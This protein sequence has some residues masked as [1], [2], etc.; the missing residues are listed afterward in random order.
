MVRALVRMRKEAGSGKGIER[1][2]YC[3]IE[4][5]Y[6]IEN[7]N[8][9]V[10]KVSNAILQG[11]KIQEVLRWSQEVYKWSLPHYQEIVLSQEP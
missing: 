2:A 3:A 5:R 11:S 7:L 6:K 8:V 4:R 1:H 10:E 9:Y